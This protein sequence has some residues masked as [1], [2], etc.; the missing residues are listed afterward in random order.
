[1]SETRGDPKPGEPGPAKPQPGESKPDQP[2]PAARP[3]NSSRREF[4]IG[5]A[6]AGVAGA[7]GVFAAR[8]L[9]GTRLSANALARSSPTRR[10]A[11]ARP[12]WPRSGTGNPTGA[13]WTALKRRLH[14][15]ALVRPGEPSYIQASR[16]FQTRFDSLEPA[17]I[18]YCRSSAD[19]AT[20]LSF[21]RAFDIPV[22]LRCGGHSYA[23]WSTV[24]GGLVIDIS[25][26]NTAR[27]SQDASGH[28]T[29][30]VGAG[31]D[32]IHFY[33][34]LA[35]RGLAVPAGSCPTVGVAGLTLGGGVGVL[36]RLY[37]LTSD[38]LE[39]VRLVT[40]SGAVLDCD[41][42]H[43]SDLYW[44][45][46][47]GGGGNFGVATSF[48]FRAHRM[49]RLHVFSLTF[50]WPDA[51]RVVGAWQ[52]W[53]PHAPGRLWSSM[54]LSARFGGPPALSVGGTFAGPPHRLA[55]HLDDL[56]SRI[57]TGPSTEFIRQQA[58]LNAMLLEADCSAIP[59]HACHTGP[60]GQLPRVPSFAKSDFFTR[61]LNESGIRV[62]LAGI[63]RLRGIQG[64]AG[65]L[66][67]VALDA[68]G[69]AINKPSPTATA[70]VHRNALFL[71]QYS[72][73]WTS[74]GARSGVDNQHRWL[75]AYYRS[76][77]PHASGQAYQNYIDPEL[78]NWRH[79]Y[80]GA[81]YERLTEIKSTYD[82][83]NLF[84]FPQSI[85]PV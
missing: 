11:F 34:E 68:C 51:A 64:A 44:A 76:L 55:R 12:V 32:L 9:G 18:A 3:P 23:G 7:G 83:R 10:L 20:C 49:D 19:V 24:T 75:R 22:R 47:G 74:R 69:G 71:A 78:A 5:A 28:H 58:Y 38:N 26:M 70:F 33:S 13:D 21:V 29:V 16:L 73:A 2:V 60:G 31:L 59:L 67:S 77:R 62:L 81:N 56:Y 45:C 48:T 53:A 6:T 40:A 54:Q 66:G 37:G 79:A 39:A 14:P 30:A 57:G 17:G 1:M 41:D 46:R 25:A 8:A 15:Q 72:T 80:Y 52:A 61:P 85:E 27:F 43:D 63:E 42:S 82:P 65:G 36:S 50:A 35:A 84:R 4:L